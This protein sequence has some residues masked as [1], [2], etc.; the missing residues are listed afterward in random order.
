[1]NVYEVIRSRRSVRTYQEKAVSQEALTRILE[2]AR[3]AP[4]G[5]NRQPWKFVVV[6]NKE[7]RKRPV[8]YTHLRAH[9]T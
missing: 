3:M 5:K 9:E 8:S 4:S 1:M 7:T 2:T 6:T